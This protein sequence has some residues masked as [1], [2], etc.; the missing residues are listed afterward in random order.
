MLERIKKWLSYP[1][2]NDSE[3]NQNHR[4]KKLDEELIQ[5][6]YNF[7]GRW[8]LVIMIL[9]ITYYLIVYLLF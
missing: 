6:I 5:K 2:I 7:R 4:N 9:V 1:E 3:L 8:I